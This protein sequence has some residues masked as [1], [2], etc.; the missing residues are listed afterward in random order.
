MLKEEML[1]LA[2]A[3]EGAEAK[4]AVLRDCLQA[5][6]LRSFHEAEAFLSVA[7]IGDL[8]GQ[9]GAAGVSGGAAGLEFVL[10]D[11]KDYKPER[12]LFAAKRRLW[13]MGLDPR[14][15]FARKLA[16]HQ[17][18]VKV[19]GLLAEAGLPEETGDPLG[20]RIAIDIAPRERPETA[21]KIVERYGLRFG[22]RSIVRGQA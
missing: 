15:A 14:I 22:L 11:K 7:L 13:F 10:L 9:S 20:F 12:W 1:E 18:W 17:G 21:A 16:V 19:P 3:A 4:R 8:G 6:V 5:S 2:V